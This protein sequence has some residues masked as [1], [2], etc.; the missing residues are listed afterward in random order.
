[1]QNKYATYTYECKCG[2]PFTSTLFQ[3]ESTAGL[4]PQYCQESILDHIY[5]SESAVSALSMDVIARLG[6]SKCEWILIILRHCYSLPDS[7]SLSDDK[8]RP[9]RIFDR[10]RRE[11]LFHQKCKNQTL[12]SSSSS[13]H[14]HTSSSFICLRQTL[15]TNEGAG[16]ASKH[17]CHAAPPTTT[18]T[19]SVPPHT[20]AA[21][22][23]QR[24]KARQPRILRNA[25]VECR[26]EEK[27]SSRNIFL[28]VLYS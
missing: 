12:F 24:A 22:L 20:A 2:R 19:P 8:S 7:S 16:T 18:M 10:E 23:A 6:A 25:C 21:S 28:F 5:E 9:P 13:S 11:T 3:L 1:M 14:S 17:H 4:R 15:G 27:C 26:R